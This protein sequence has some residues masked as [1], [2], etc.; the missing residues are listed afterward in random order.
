[1]LPILLQVVNSILKLRFN[2]EH[3]ARNDDV[4][5]LGSRDI[6]ITS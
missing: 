2:N 1:M 6:L 4:Y 5:M 3:R